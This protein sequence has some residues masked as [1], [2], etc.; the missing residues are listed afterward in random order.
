MEHGQRAGAGTELLGR[1]VGD[2]GKGCGGAREPECQGVDGWLRSARVTGIHGQGWRRGAYVT[3]IRGATPY[4]ETF[5]SRRGRVAE[6]GGQRAGWAREARATSD[7]NGSC[8]KA[9]YGPRRRPNI[10]DCIKIWE[11]HVKGQ[12]LMA[13]FLCASSVGACGASGG[14]GGG[15]G[16]SDSSW[17]GTFTGPLTSAGT[18]S[19]GSAVPTMSQTTSLSISQTGTTLRW[20]VACGATVNANV[21]GN[22][23]MV[24]QYSCPSQMSGSSTVQLTVSSGVLTLSGNSLSVNL[25]ARATVTGSTGMSNSCNISVIGTLARL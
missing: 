4:D 15:G 3:G 7:D 17:T 5:D 8:I 20:M 6:V 18:C 2:R 24:Q 22:T 9:R 21:S 16:F 13:A 11:V 12:K 10:H 25:M 19:D 14:G 23:A 1:C